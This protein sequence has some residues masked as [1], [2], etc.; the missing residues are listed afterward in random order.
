MCCTQM[1]EISEQNTDQMQGT[2]TTCFCGR[3]TETVVLGLIYTF[4]CKRIVYSKGAGKSFVPRV[5]LT[6]V[7]CVSCLFVYF[8]RTRVGSF[9]ATRRE[10]REEAAS[11]LPRHRRGQEACE[12]RS[13]PSAT[14]AGQAPASNC[15]SLLESVGAEQPPANSYS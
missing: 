6:G 7:R 5:Q 2:L 8:Y 13:S 1:F 12:R 10:A 9:P 14:H 4:H 3:S 15:Q 11:S